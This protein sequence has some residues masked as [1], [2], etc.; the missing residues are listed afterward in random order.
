MES[1]I[2]LMEPVLC[3]TKIL[4]G[5]ATILFGAGLSFLC[6]RGRIR[7]RAT[8]NPQFLRRYVTDDGSLPEVNPGSPEQLHTAIADQLE[9]HFVRDGTVLPEGHTWAEL[10]SHMNHNSPDPLYLSAILLDM[11]NL[12]SEHYINALKILTFCLGWT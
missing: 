5:V 1:L 2:E 12:A 6:R 4:T 3:N 8:E 9:F 11:G 7:A 10:A